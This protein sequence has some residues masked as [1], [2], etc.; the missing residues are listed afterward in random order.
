MRRVCAVV[1]SVASAIL[2][3]PSASAYAIGNASATVSS[4]A[5]G[6]TY[7]LNFSGPINVQIL[8]AE[9]GEQ[10]D[11]FISDTQPGGSGTYAWGDQVWAGSST[12]N[13]SGTADPMTVAGPYYLE[14][15]DAFGTIGSS[16]FTI[17]SGGGG[18]GTYTLSV[19]APTSGGYVGSYPSGISCGNG[20]TSCA[21]RFSAG[22]TVE[23]TAAASPGY[24]FTGWSGACTGS[25]T[26]CSL[27]MT[28]AR[29]VTATFLPNTYAIDVALAG[30]GS[31]HV[32]S[33]YTGINCP[34]GCHATFSGGLVVR[35]T[36]T[37]SAGTVFTGW[38]G[39]C[40]SVTNYCDFTMFKNYSVTAIFV[41]P[42]LMINKAG[43]GSGVITSDVGNLDCG[44][45]C[46]SDYAPGTVVTLTEAPDA[47]SIFSG[48]GSLSGCSSL[49]T[50]CQVTM[51]KEVALSP[52][53][54]RPTL[55]VISNG[56]TITSYPSGI[57]CGSTCSVAFTPGQSVTLSETPDSGRVFTGWNGA[58]SSDPC[59]V[60]MSQSRSV[61]ASFGWEQFDL[62][63]DLTGSGSGRVY[64][65]LYGDP[66]FSCD[67]SCTQSVGYTDDVTLQ[68]SP[69]AGSTFTGWSGAGCSGTG[70][71]VVTMNAAASVLATF[72]L[73]PVLSISKAGE[74]QG[75]VTSSTPGI[76]CGPTCTASFSPGT[77]ITLTATPDAASV[78]VGWSGSGCSGDATCQVTMNQARAV[79]ASFEV[80]PTAVVKGKLLK[81][82]RTSG[83]YRLY[84][85]GK[86]VFYTTWVTPQQG[87]APLSIGL[88]KYVG[89][90]SWKTTAEATF[91]T[92]ADGSVV[93]YI[94]PTILKVG[95][96]YRLRSTFA[97]NSNVLGATS[98]WYY[99]KVT[100]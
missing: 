15:S 68:A 90:G 43:S 65:D 84:H 22:S 51:S 7:A 54:T 80:K 75:T 70:D 33:S 31:G 94:A 42:T 62:N 74:G 6:G 63:V 79:T 73:S 23:L 40:N 57:E 78:F 8:G 50:T 96:S 61:T 76:A 86:K 35:L 41:K 53:F 91:D 3:L 46:S 21:A 98:S 19:S 11:I 95:Q 48:W 1:L 18:G 87:S 82:Y 28:S 24:N 16:S 14:V 89:F 71:C 39:D 30:D 69:D 97:G 93:I 17:G 49:A 37:A 64:G 83:K 29:S 72:E 44:S 4:P 20:A 56:G 47:D 2:A 32:T 45:T 26:G 27:S 60:S 12:V 92:A 77:V 36:A 99:F 85:S 88:Q 66:L 10:F 55:T 67:A 58:C 38:S 5:S 81:Y 59:T 13:Y 34:S 52:T 100:A 9:S 25:A